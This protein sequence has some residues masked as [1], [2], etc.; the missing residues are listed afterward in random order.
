[1]LDNSLSKLAFLRNWQIA[2]GIVQPPLVA[3]HPEFVRISRRAMRPSHTNILKSLSF[4]EYPFA[5]PFSQLSAPAR[6]RPIF[7]GTRETDRFTAAL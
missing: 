1:M 4:L 2:V 6:K 3:I 7:S 5:G